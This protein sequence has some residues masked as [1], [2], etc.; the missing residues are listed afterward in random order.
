MRAFAVINFRFRQFQIR[1]FQFRRSIFDQQD[2]QTVGSG[3]I[4]L[5]HD[6]AETM[7]IDQIRIHP[8]LAG[9]GG[10]LVHIDFAR[11]EQHLLDPP[12]HRVAIDVGI[13][14]G[15]IR[16]QRLNLGDGIGV[17]PPVPQPDI[18]EQRSILGRIHGILIGDRENPRGGASI[19]SKGR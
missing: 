10:Q 2:G 17:C 11:G 15:V 9:V 18:F 19:Q 1:R 8:T 13:G 5:R 3:F 4:D 6:H 12:A 14:K 7:G 16:T